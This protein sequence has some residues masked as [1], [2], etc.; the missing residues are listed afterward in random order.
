M[1]K[2]NNLLKK[3]LSNGGKLMILSFLIF[4]ASGYLCLDVQDNLTNQL[5]LWIA[6]V[7]FEFSLSLDFFKPMNN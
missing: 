6:I 2:L 4:G 1:I 3:R 7:M 5:G